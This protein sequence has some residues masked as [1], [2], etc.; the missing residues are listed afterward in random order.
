MGRQLL[1]PETST[2]VPRESELPLVLCAPARAQSLRL[3]CLE[4]ARL[5]PVSR[6]ALDSLTHD[7]N[8]AIRRHLRFECAQTSG[9]VGRDVFAVVNARQRRKHGLAVGPIMQAVR[10]GRSS[11]TIEMIDQAS[12]A[13]IDLVTAQW[14]SWPRFV[15]RAL[16]P[17][18]PVHFDSLAIH[19]ELAQHETSAPRPRT[20]RWIVEAVAA[21]LLS[22]SLLSWRDDRPCSTVAKRDGRRRRAAGSG[23]KDATG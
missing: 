15:A 3:P 1:V 6:R 7:S 14:P 4:V 17:P 19:A 18:R 16:A 10:K 22:V 5:S 11:P 13:R 20:C 21:V 9:K 2:T 23:D 12:D 8:A